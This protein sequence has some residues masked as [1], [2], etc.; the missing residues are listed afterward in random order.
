[1]S[2]D[3]YGLWNIS[4]EEVS[5]LHTEFQGQLK[6]WESEYSHATNP[7]RG[8]ILSVG[9]TSGHQIVSSIYA[10]LNIVRVRRCVCRL[11]CIAR[12]G[13]VSQ[14]EF[15]GRLDGKKHAN[16]CP[17][18]QVDLLCGINKRARLYIKLR[19]PSL[20]GQI[21]SADVIEVRNVS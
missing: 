19:H 16:N 7:T 5:V 20:H 15:Q 4:Q 11:E 6:G 13:S 17:Y 1:M 8:L 9:L 2:A 21:S 10:W 18:K 14:R 12:G 3:A